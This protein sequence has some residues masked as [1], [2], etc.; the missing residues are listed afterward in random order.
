MCD[1]S[2]TGSKMLRH[3]MPQASTGKCAKTNLALGLGQALMVEVPGGRDWKTH[4][5]FEGVPIQD[6]DI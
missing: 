1:V 3:D 5:L 4:A 6:D 2:Q